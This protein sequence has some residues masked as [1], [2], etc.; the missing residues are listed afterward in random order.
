MI[1]KGEYYEIQFQCEYIY[2]VFMEGCYSL[3][4]VY[5]SLERK[6]LCFN[7][8]YLNKKDIWAVSTLSSIILLNF[9]I[10]IWNLHTFV[11]NG[12]ILSLI[13][14]SLNIGVLVFRNQLIKL[15]GGL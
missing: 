7:D 11:V 14:G 10:G 15:K 2:R 13:I 1:N 4:L 6:R 5:D 9:V 12:Y 3:L 8:V